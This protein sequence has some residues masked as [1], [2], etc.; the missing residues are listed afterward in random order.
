MLA[1]KSESTND[2]IVRMYK[3]GISIESIAKQLMMPKDNVPKILEKYMPDYQ[4]YTP[5]PALVAAAKGKE[6]NEKPKGRFRD[7]LKRDKGQRDNGHAAEHTENTQKPQEES[8]PKQSAPKQSI[9]LAMNE[10]GFVDGVVRGIAA[11]LQNGKDVSTIADFFNR[12]EEDIIAVR[13]CMD[14]HFK[15][16]GEKSENVPIVAPES[17]TPVEYPT[18][19]GLDDVVYTFENV[20]AATASMP[21]I[22]PISL[23]D[24]DKQLGTAN[25]DVYSTG[26]EPEEDFPEAQL[27]FEDTQDEEVEDETLETETNDTAV[28]V[29]EEASEE[30]D[31][32]EETSVTEVGL[33]SFE[34]ETAGDEEPGEQVTEEE[35]FAAEVETAEV[36]SEFKNTYNSK[37]DD[38]M[39]PMEKMKKF[40]EEQIE[41]NN[42]KIADLKAKREETVG[43]NGDIESEISEINSSITE[44]DSKIEETNE[45]ISQSNDKL[46]ELRA[47]IEEIE[48][49]I[50]T[51]REEAVS[52]NEKNEELKEKSGELET[53]KNEID[54]T[55]A[56][57]DKEIAEVEKENEEFAAYCK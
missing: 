5:N 39:S 38:S 32:S 9:N 46:A 44:N 2:K 3:E 45:Q 11:M 31:T 29:E 4:S 33:F 50:V 49:K 36:D 51:L 41:L 27:P 7:M 17:D 20:N 43:S 26:E 25:S 34:S 28:T 21:S 22:D 42:A 14:E 10:S 12:D 55:V 57:I 40:A 24:L 1:K 8:K 37:E 30:A 35:V 23:D 56:D 48:A 15:R 16:A 19:S 54:S 6:K 18:L 53:K 47:Q 13:E 52:L